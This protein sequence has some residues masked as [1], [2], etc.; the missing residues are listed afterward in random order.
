VQTIRIR[1]TASIIAV[2]D[3]YMGEVHAE[4]G[5]Y[6][7]FRPQPTKA[8]VIRQIQWTSDRL[9]LA[10]TLDQEEQHLA[11]ARPGMRDGYAPRDMSLVRAEAEA[12]ILRAHEA[13]RAAVRAENDRRRQA[14]DGSINRWFRRFGRAPVGGRP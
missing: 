7:E 5:M 4:D 3:G 8:E 13:E 9:S 2:G 14:N 10:T 6:I 12:K 1:A 11:A